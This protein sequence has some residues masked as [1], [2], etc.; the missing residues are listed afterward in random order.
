MMMADGHDLRDTS[1]LVC[2]DC[3]HIRAL[4]CLLLQSFGAGEVLEAADAEEAY[5]LIVERGP[6]LLVTDCRMEPTDGMELT[7]RIRKSREAADPAMPVIMMTSYTEINWVKMARDSGVNAFLAKPLSSQALYNK[8]CEALEDK[9]PLVRAVD[10]CGPDRRIG[11]P[12]IFAGENRR[13]A[14]PA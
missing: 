7:R 4:V 11:R 3:G 8:V 6:D 9:R 13:T 14:V 10:Y 12:E 1:I 2:D 5:S